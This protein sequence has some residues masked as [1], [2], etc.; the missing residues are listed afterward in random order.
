MERLLSQYHWLK[1][2]NEERLAMRVAFGIPRTGGT[3]MEDNRLKSDGCTDSDLRKVNIESMQLFTGS[4]ETDFDALY[5][6]SITK[7]REEIAEKHEEEEKAKHEALMKETIAHSISLTTSLLD[8]I[9]KLPLEAKQNIK[10][11]LDIM[12]GESVAPVVKKEKKN[13]KA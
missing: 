12:L 7:L 1:L 2:S 6:L 5:E 3:I 11:K 8:T 10:E 13:V 4:K 9:S